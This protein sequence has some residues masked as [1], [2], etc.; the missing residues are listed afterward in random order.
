MGASGTPPSG[1]ADGDVVVKIA[2]AKA[3]LSELIQRAEAGERVIIARGD[4]PVVELRPVPRP[5]SP[6]GLYTDLAGPVDMD[7]LH[8]EMDDGWSGSDL[9]DFEGDLERELQRG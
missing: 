8:A 3:R 9:D 4:D 1:A 5:R 2:D 6:I 7:R